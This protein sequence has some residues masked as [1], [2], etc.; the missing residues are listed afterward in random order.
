MVNAIVESL[1]SEGIPDKRV[2]VALR[3]HHGCLPT[4]LVRDQI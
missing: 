3:I 4:R 2:D 1:K